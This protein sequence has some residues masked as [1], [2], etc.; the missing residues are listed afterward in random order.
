MA[1]GTRYLKLDEANAHFGGDSDIL[2]SGS[3][4]DAM[5]LSGDAP[6]PYPAIAA[7]PVYRP[8]ILPAVVAGPAVTAL[9]RPD[10]LADIPTLAPEPTPTPSPTPGPTR[11]PVTPLPTTDMYAAQVVVTPAPQKMSKLMIIIMATAAVVTLCLLMLM[12]FLPRR[13]GTVTTP[14]MPGPGGR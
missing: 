8:P 12:F 13:L 14:S 6:N 5:P 4:L 2:L 10:A 9:V 11:A 3:V 1:S 7:T